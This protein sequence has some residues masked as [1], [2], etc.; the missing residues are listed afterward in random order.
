MANILFVVAVILFQFY[1][2]SEG[3]VCNKET[4]HEC[5]C[6]LECAKTERIY[7]KCESLIK[8]E[9]VRTVH[10]IG[11]TKKESIIDESSI[12]KRLSKFLRENCN[13]SPNICGEIEPNITSDRIFLLKIFKL[14]DEIQINFSVT[15]SSNRLALTRENMMDV[16][17]ILEIFAENIYSFADILGPEIVIRKIFGNYFQPMTEYCFENHKSKRDTKDRSIIEIRIIIVALLT[18]F[19]LIIIN[20][21]IFT[22]RC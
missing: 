21:L 9:Y 1:L 17:Y 8:D 12:R 10:L 3:L 15:K 22:G 11:S 7:E 4:G 18:I 2:G 13:Q 5:I 16:K 19:S 6:L 20:C 14:L